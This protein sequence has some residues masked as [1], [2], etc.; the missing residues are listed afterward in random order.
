MKTKRVHDVMALKC[1]HDV[2]ALNNY[3]IA[4]ANLPS[5]AGGLALYLYSL[6]VVMCLRTG[7]S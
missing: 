5:I 3:S 6:N 4:F 1:V 7:N 2:V